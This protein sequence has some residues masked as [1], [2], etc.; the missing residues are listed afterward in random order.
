[1]ACTATKPLVWACELCTT[2][3]LY[4]DTAH[5]Y[6]FY[7]TQALTWTTTT[8]TTTTTMAHAPLPASLLAFL[9]SHASLPSGAG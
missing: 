1:M 2:H 7:P 3:D 6:A 5:P 4:T 8:T 9:P